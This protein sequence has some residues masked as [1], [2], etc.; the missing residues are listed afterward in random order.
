MWSLFSME[1]A[2]SCAVVFIAGIVR[3][4]SG[5]AF[6][7]VSGAGLTLLL[8]AHVFVPVVLAIELVLGLSLVPREMKNCSWPTISPMVVSAGMGTFIGIVLLQGLPEV[9]SKTLL[10]LAIAASALAMLGAPRLVLG[11]ARWMPLTAGTISGLMN[12]AF[13]MGGPPAVLFLSARLPEASRLRGSI[14]LYF[15]LIDI[16]AL[17]YLGFSGGINLHVLSLAALLLPTSLLGVKLGERIYEFIDPER[18]RPTLLIGLLIIGL[19]FLVTGG[20]RWISG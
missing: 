9:P 3:G 14:I 12:G 19:V 16:V 6:A 13:A 10:G 8:P 20:A 4:W 2:A 15:F 11:P 18:F 17:L 5:F 1:I 7:I